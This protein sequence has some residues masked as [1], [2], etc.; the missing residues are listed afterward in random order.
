MNASWQAG[1][2]RAKSLLLFTR[3]ILTLAT[4]NL[5]YKGVQ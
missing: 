3:E 4:L 5:H 2:D 1:T